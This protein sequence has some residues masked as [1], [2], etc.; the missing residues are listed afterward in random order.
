ML[1]RLNLAGAGVRAEGEG[2]QA[3]GGGRRHARRARMPPR[4]MSFPHQ[5]APCRA[6]LPPMRLQYPAGSPATYLPQRKPLAVGARNLCP[7]ATIQSA[8]RRCTS[9]RRCGRYWQESSRTRAPAWGWREKGRRGGAGRGAGVHEGGGQAV[10]LRRGRPCTTLCRGLDNSAAN[11]RWLNHRLAS[12]CQHETATCRHPPGAPR[13]RPPQ[14]AARSPA[15][16]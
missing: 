7:L 9:V 15:R 3:E 4:P 2:R 11:E 14:R 13:G 10:A 1:R 16:C 12:A 6:L 8:P 5:P